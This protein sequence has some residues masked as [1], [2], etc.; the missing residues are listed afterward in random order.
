MGLSVGLN[1]GFADGIDGA[2]VEGA[3]VGLQV[4]VIDGALVGN[5][6][7]DFVGFCEY[8]GCGDGSLLG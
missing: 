8:D 1:V 7:G 5:R 6:V 2:T 3:A 4:G